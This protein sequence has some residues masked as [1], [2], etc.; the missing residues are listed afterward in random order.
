MDY[1]FY[2]TLFKLSPT[3]LNSMPIYMPNTQKEGSQIGGDT[4]VGFDLGI[5]S[6]KYMAI[7]VH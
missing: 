1:S 3:L 6:C 5:N 2:I 4:E 7:R